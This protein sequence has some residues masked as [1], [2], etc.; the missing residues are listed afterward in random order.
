MKVQGP[1]PMVMT[2][3]LYEH[4]NGPARACN[5]KCNENLT[6]DARIAICEREDRHDLHYIRPVYIYRAGNT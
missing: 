5:V 4:L 3:D 1:T 2:D 6:N